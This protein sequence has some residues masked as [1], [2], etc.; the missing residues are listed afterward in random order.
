MLIIDHDTKSLVISVMCRFCVCFKGAEQPGAKCQ[1]TENTKYYSA[2]FRK[3]FYEKHNSSQHP[4]EW[5]KYKKASKEEKMEFFE[6]MKFVWIKCFI[7]TNGDILEFLM[8]SKIVEDIVAQLFLRPDDDLDAL[9]LEKS[10]ALFKK[11]LDTTTLYCITVKNVIRFELALD[12]TSIGL[13]FHQTFAVIDKHKEA[14]G[15]TKLVGFKDHIVSQY[16]YVGVTINLQCISDILSFPHVWLFALVADS[17]MHRFVSYL[18][19]QIRFCPNGSLENLHLIVVPFYNRHTTEN[20]DA[21]ICCILDVLY[22][23]WRSKIITFS[24]DGENTMIG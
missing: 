16:V 5:E 2:P 21:M 23:C 11:V 7:R 3:G 17:S 20:I 24:T 4:V 15:N 1:Q 18:D 10:M 9:S 6:I 13:S 12:H 14:F 22:A 19:I 8:D